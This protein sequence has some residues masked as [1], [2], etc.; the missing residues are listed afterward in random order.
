MS[1]EHGDWQLGSWE[2]LQFCS[3]LPAK[4]YPL[5]NP[6]TNGIVYS[7]RCIVRGY[8][9]ANTATVGGALLLFDGLD[10][11]G[12]AVTRTGY[13]ASGSTAPNYF[14]PGIL[15]DIGVF[16]NTG[17]GQLTGVVYVVPLWG[18]PH[19]PPGE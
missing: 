14:Y 3:Q 11:S 7:G 18:Y 5:P 6:G 1:R 17:L 13:G 19:T 15:M 8:S 2:W 9:F 4:P 10:G 16:A 12:Q